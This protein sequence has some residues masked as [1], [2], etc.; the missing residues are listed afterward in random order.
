MALRAHIQLHYIAIFMPLPQELQT[1]VTLTL[2]SLA[3]LSHTVSLPVILPLCFSYLLLPIV[4]ATDWVTKPFFTPRHSAH[5]ALRRGEAVQAVQEEEQQQRRR[6]GGDV[7]AQRR[8]RRRR[9]EQAVLHLPVRA[10][11]QGAAREVLHHAPLRHDARLLARVPMR[12]YSI[13]R[14]IH[15]GGEQMR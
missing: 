15:G 4:S 13:D 10:A 9:Q 1:S 6:Q 11:R 3:T 8:R 2:I 7:R 14:S 5:G 12:G